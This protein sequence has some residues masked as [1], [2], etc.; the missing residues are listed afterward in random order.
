MK[1]INKLNYL[2]VFYSNFTVIYNCTMHN[3]IKQI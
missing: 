1:Y 2:N 3:D